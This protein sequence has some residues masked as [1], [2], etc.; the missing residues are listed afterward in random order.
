MCAV[1]HE[2]SFDID[3]LSLDC[4]RFQFDLI[5]VGI[6]TIY[7]KSFAHCAV[8]HHGLV[9]SNSERLEMLEDGSFIE[10]IDPQTKVVE[11]MSLFFW[12]S[13]A[14]GAQGPL[15]IDQIDNGRAGAP[16]NHGILIFLPLDRTA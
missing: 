16:M 5:S 2:R 6:E 7:R 8:S 9:R 11:I 14:S 13:P 15:R 4:R 3:I 10:G 12:R 1:G